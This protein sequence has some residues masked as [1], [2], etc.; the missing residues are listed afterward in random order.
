M[1]AVLKLR[2]IYSSTAAGCRQESMVIEWMPS[3]NQS[4]L[5]VSVQSIL[6]LPNVLYLVRPFERMN[7]K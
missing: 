1:E 3:R 5:L 4:L 2:P 7:R 6:R